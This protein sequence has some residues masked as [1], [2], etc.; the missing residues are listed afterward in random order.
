MYAALISYAEGR[1]QQTPYCHSPRAPWVRRRKHLLI[2][3]IS[4]LSLTTLELSGWQHSTPL[5]RRRDCNDL[6]GPMTFRQNY[7]IATTDLVCFTNIHHYFNI[8]LPTTTWGERWKNKVIIF[9]FRI[10]LKIR[11]TN[12][13]LMHSQIFSFQMIISIYSTSPKLYRLF[14]LCCVVLLGLERF[15]PYRSGHFTGIGVIYWGN[16]TVTP[17]TNTV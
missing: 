7:F 10:I 9:L 5:F 4:V 16:C 17:F 11:M 1:R 3:L 15:Y 8:T 12:V 14:A 13:F 2:T 6:S